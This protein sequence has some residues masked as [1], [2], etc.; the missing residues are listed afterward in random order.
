MARNQ[1][2]IEPKPE[3]K[4]ADGAMAKGGPWFI[5][6]FSA[7]CGLSHVQTMDNHAQTMLKP[8]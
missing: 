8:C 3:L 6:E 1:A 2:A 5:D 7:S 4:T